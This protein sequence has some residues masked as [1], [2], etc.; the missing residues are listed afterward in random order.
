MIKVLTQLAPHL[1]KLY[2][3]TEQYTSQI[4]W[5]W[6]IQSLI[7]AKDQFSK[8]T[9]KRIRKINPNAKIILERGS[10]HIQFQYKILCE[11]YFC[12]ELNRRRP[13]LQTYLM[14][15][16]FKLFIFRAVPHYLTDSFRFDLFVQRQ[17]I[18]NI[19]C[20]LFSRISKFYVRPLKLKFFFLQ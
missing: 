16:C 1:K 18:Q 6:Y 4:A 8:L 17:Q 19:C 12:D 7:I 14:I 3:K 10:T 20:G 5:Y 2:T 11:E 13:S 9:I 15:L